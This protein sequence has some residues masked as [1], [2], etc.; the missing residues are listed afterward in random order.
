[1]ARP[2]VHED[3]RFLEELVAE[4]V[5]LH[6]ERM[7]LHERAGQLQQ[8][9]QEARLLRREDEGVAGRYKRV[10]RHPSELDATAGLTDRAGRRVVPVGT[11]ACTGSNRSCT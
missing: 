5:V 2:A 8:L 9:L 7:A 3:E 10:H 1:M 11:R 6:A 4:H